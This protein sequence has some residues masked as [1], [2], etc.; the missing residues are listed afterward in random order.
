MAKNLNKKID[1]SVVIVTYN[2]FDT[3]KKCLESLNKTILKNTFEVIV[4]DNNSKDDSA[5]LL[6]E[7]CQK[8]DFL[9]FIKNK[10]N[11][12]FSKA[13]NIGIKRT[14]QSRYVLFLN[15]D[16]VVYKNT[17]DGMIEFM[18]KTKDAGVSTCFMELLNGELDDSSHRGFPT[19]WNSFT[20]FSGLAKMFPKSKLFSGYNMTYLDLS[21]T[22]EVDALA[23][24]FMLVRRGVG[25]KL[26]WWD[27][28]FFFYG[29]DIDF[30]FRIKELGYKVYFVPKFR[31]L[32]HKGISSGIKKISKDLSKAT[33]ETKLFVTNHRFMAMKIFYN[34]HYRKDM[35]FFV[36]WIIFLAID[37]KKFLAET[38]L[39]NEG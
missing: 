16:T 14:Q 33:L 21:S 17:V 26:N 18:D 8:Y 20:Y 1:L 30:C 5:K 36:T 31:A 28:D 24:S 19:P 34:K 22:H 37:I 9:T 25:E 10:K 27:E 2:S 39:K 11:D 3:I 32:H 23:G 29:E 6:S 12:G 15:P 35:P 38:S 7:L 4:V 13:N